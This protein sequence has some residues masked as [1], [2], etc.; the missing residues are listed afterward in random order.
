MPIERREILFYLN[1]VK[2]IFERE[3]VLFGSSL[4]RDIS[5]CNLTWVWS[6]RSVS[7]A[8]RDSAERLR[9]VIHRL[10]PANPVVVFS[11]FKKGLIGKGADEIFLV[12]EDIMRE[13]FIR[14]C[15]RQ[16]IMVPRKAK[17]EIAVDDLMIGL[18][19][20]KEN[21]TLSLE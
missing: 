8:S 21:D 3:K 11:S 9:D 5:D 19:I 18:R 17:K 20:V 13:A 10:D 6:S 1:E 16:S 12:S 4:P 2:S 15:A 7:T 14:E